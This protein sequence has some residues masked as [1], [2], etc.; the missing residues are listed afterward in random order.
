MVNFVRP[1]YTVRD[2]L[3]RQLRQRTPG[4]AQDTADDIHKLMLGILRERVK[5]PALLWEYAIGM[6]DESFVAGELLKNDRFLTAEGAI[7]LAGMDYYRRE[8]ANRVVTW[9]GANWF[10][11]IVAGCTIGVSVWGIV[12]G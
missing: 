12:G 8:T 10:A 11:A 5:D 4:G 1:T 7:T 9:L 6:P 2:S 3:I